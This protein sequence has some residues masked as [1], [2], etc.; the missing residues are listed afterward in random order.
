MA[1]SALDDDGKPVDWWFMYKV[2]GESTT[3]TGA[4]APVL[5]GKRVTGLEYIYFDASAPRG[6]KLALSSCTTQGGALQKTLNQIYG[7]PKKSIGWWFYNDENPITG[8]VNSSRG[9]TK[10]VVAFDLSSN[11]AFWLIQ[12]T[13]KFPPSGKYSFPKTGQ[14]NAQTLLCITLRDATVAQS[15]AKQM[16]VAQ[17]PNVYLASEIPAALAKEPNDARVKLMKDQVATGDTPV[18]VVIPFRSRA[19]VKFMS[20]AKNKAWD[21]DFYN[22]LVGPTLKENLDVETWEHDP[23]P[24]PADSDK[25]HTVLDMKSVNLKALGIDLAW[26]EEDDHAKLAISARSE[27]AHY[28]CVGDINYTIA[29]RKRGGGTVAFQCEPLWASL[30]SILEGTSA[31]PH[32]RTAAT[33]RTARAGTKPAARRATAKPVNGDVRRRHSNVRQARP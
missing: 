18:H 15:I 27:P 13:P 14:P 31:F 25:Q 1:L 29:Q 17:Q 28:V 33:E 10:G 16:Y 8:E 7:A 32:T 11:T 5:D 21:L 22:D 24:P 30:V 20:I 4:K 12:S 9:H 23:V 2:A 3:S 6:S 26:S 19:G